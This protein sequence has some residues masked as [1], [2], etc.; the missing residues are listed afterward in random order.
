MAQECALGTGMHLA[1]DL[2]IYEVVGEDNAPIPP[3]QPGAKL[4]VTALSN[5][6]MP[7]VRYE[8][9]DVGAL[10]SAPTRLARPPKL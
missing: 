6:V 1:E 3:G 8:L 9:S 10:E 2:S 7:L 5:D 4:L